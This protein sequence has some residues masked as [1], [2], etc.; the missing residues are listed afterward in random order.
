M[1]EVIP[2]YT[3]VKNPNKIEIYEVKKAKAFVFATIP[4]SAQR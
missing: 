1:T 2:M 4:F 3:T